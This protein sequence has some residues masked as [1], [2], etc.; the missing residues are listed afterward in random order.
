MET[1][2][3]ISLVSM[4]STWQ[5]NSKQVAMRPNIIKTRPVMP[6]T[7]YWKTCRMTPIYDVQYRGSVEFNKERKMLSTIPPRRMMTSRT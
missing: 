5:Q 7:D 3:G 1:L 6:T 2:G 4:T